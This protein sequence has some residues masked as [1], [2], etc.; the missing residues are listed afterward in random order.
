MGCGVNLGTSMSYFCWP[1]EWKLDIMEVITFL[2]FVPF[3]GGGGTTY[4]Q[5]KNLLRA[6]SII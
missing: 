3:G 6:M 5:I 1:L 4:G 2:D